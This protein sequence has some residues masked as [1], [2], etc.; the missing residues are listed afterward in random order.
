M[1]RNRTTVNGAQMARLSRNIL[2]LHVKCGAQFGERIG[3]VGHCGAD[4][5]VWNLSKACRPADCILDS[6]GLARFRE[7]LHAR[8]GRSAK[9]STDIRD[10]REDIESGDARLLGANRRN[11]TQHS[12]TGNPNVTGKSLKS[13]PAAMT[14]PGRCTTGANRRNSTQHGAT[15]KPKMMRNRPKTWTNRLPP[16]RQ[17]I[18][19][20]SDARLMHHTGLLGATRRNEAQLKIQTLRVSS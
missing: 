14:R 15:Q 16:P 19:P 8:G 10:G 1:L 13:R 4:W 12:A 2:Y 3:A 6:P 5:R 9:T 17:C 11:S 20:F 18:T 7:A